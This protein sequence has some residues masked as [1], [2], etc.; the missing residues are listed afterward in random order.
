MSI[1]NKKIETMERQELSKL[2]LK[3]LQDMVDYCIDKVPFYKESLRKAGI[4][5]G[6]QIKCLSDISKIPF[7]TKAD[8]ANNYPKGLLAVPMEEIA[9]I[10]ASS[11]TTGKP[12]IGYYTKNDLETWSEITARVLSLNGLTSNDIIQISFGYGLFTG[13]FG[14][15]HG[16]EKIGTTIIPASAGDSKKQLI[17]M[18][19]IGVTTLMATPSYAVYLSELIKNS[20]IPISEFKVNRVIVG[21]ERCTKSMKE[22]IERNI[23]CEVFDVYGLTECFGPGVAGECEYHNG[24]HISEDIFYPEIIDVK[25]GEVL[26]DGKQGELVFTSLYREAA[27][28]IRYRTGDIT[29]LTHEKCKCGRT[30]VRMKA[31]FARVDDM[32][33]FKG[34]NIYPTQVEHIL[35]KI[36]G[37]SPHYLIKLERKDYIDT[38]TLYIELEEQ[39]ENYSE[40]NIRRIR[41][42]IK[43]KLEE[44]I[45]VKMNIELV[46]PNTLERFTGKSKRVED[47][48]YVAES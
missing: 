47:L 2:Q 38:A 37:I 13:A 30:S 33:V 5:S 12:K 31:P 36:S 32:F 35:D 6:K 8:I 1:Y 22:M 24:M 10:H 28:L 45:I 43:D 44:T 20:D 25:T 34:I 16:A 23:G 29:S 17:M 40:Y 3:R 7:T 15:H 41:K 18:H 39:K 9:R 14:F 19:D 46:E 21:A 4:N 11:G 26:E 48:R 42:E 27:P